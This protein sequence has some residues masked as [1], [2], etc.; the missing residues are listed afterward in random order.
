MLI[1][2]SFCIPGDLGMTGTSQVLCDGF[3]LNEV[4][5]EG[6]KERKQGKAQIQESRHIAQV[7]AL[8]L[9]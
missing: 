4:G 5:G 8:A 7:L 2:Y 6:Q 3:Q 9:S 1:S